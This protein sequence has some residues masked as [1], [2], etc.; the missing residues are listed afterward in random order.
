MRRAGI[1]LVILAVLALTG[2]ITANAVVSDTS[3]EAYF[4]S[5]LLSGS[6]EGAEGVRILASGK[7]RTVNSQYLCFDLVYNAG[8]GTS[9]GS[10]EL[11]S[12]LSYESSP[13]V[14]SLW[15]ND[16]LRGGGSTSGGAGFELQELPAPCA[17]IAGRA[18]SGETVEDTMLLSEVCDY[19]PIYVDSWGSTALDEELQAVFD[20]ELRLPV[21]EDTV[22]KASVTRD[23]VGAL[24][25]YNCYIV[26]GTFYEIACYDLTSCCIISVGLWGE[27]AEGVNVFKDGQLYHMDM[28]WSEMHNEYEPVPESFRQVLDGFCT[29]DCAEAPGGG[30][31]LLGLGET[32]CRLVQLSPSGEF[33][34]E[35]GIPLTREESRP[36]LILGDEWFLI[37]QD[38]ELRSFVR[39][40]EGVF[41][42]GPVYDLSDT[43]V[44]D[45][46]DTWNYTEAYDFDGER[47]A[48][49]AA[50]Y[51]RY[52][53]S[54]VTQDDIMPDEPR[55][56]ILY[57]VVAT[58]EELLLSEELYCSLVT[59]GMD[60]GYTIEIE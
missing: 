31:L 41:R 32:A 37:K 54:P 13:H 28:V 18:G 47:L 14:Y 55:D 45:Y 44:F 19:W 2:L 10:F 46:G 21:P 17:A 6:R 39:D 5:T 52:V 30:A 53:G 23:E 42:P 51:I 34:S 8:A 33:L 48:V 35:L 50:R 36:R 15:I 12:T 29:W 59:N 58:P 49:L 60:P 25:E 16:Q 20:R 4:E 1:L 22:V 26:S 40:A 24:R 7:E 43:P 9:D 38:C 27:D 57:L 3:D 11:K 56:Q